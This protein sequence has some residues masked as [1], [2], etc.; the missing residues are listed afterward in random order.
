MLGLAVLSVSCQDRMEGDGRIEAAGDSSFTPVIASAGGTATIEFTTDGDWN[1]K[2]PDISSY[3][4]SSIIPTSGG[5]G[6]NV[7]TVTALRNDGTDDRSFTFDIISGGAVQNVTVTQRQKNALTVTEG[8]F[9][10]A[11]EGGQVRI[12]V[13]ANVDYEYSIEEAAASWIVPVPESRA[14]DTTEVLLNV[15]PNPDFEN[16]RTGHVTIVSGD[17]SQEITISQAALERVFE[18]T[19]ASLEIDSNGG[20]VSFSV[21]ANFEYEVTMEENDW[22][23]PKSSENGTY[24][25]TAAVNPDFG[26]RTATINVTTGVEGYSAAVT[27]QQTGVADV[28]VLW[29]HTYASYGVSLSSPVLRLAEYEDHLLVSTGSSVF[30]VNRQTGEYEQAVTLPEGMTVTSLTNDDAGN[31]IF[32]ANAAYG[33][34]LNIYSMRGMSSEPELVL[35]YD[36]SSIYSASIGNVRVRGDVNGKAVVTAS[37]DVSQYWVAWQIEGGEVT[38]TLYGAA[39]AGGSTVWSPESLC[40]APVSDELSDGLLYIGYT[41]GYSLQ[42]CASP[43]DGTWTVIHETGTD[44]NEN[45]NCIS[46]A[47]FGGRRYA[48]YEQGA[49]FSWG[50]CPEAHLI[51]ITDIAGA[52]ESVVIPSEDVSGG[53]AFTETGPGSDILLTVSDDG[54]VMYMFVTDGNYDCLTCITFTLP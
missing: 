43:A 12:E 22:L 33:S 28:N 9:E 4:W 1:A 48:A 45:F 41:T 15:L 19:P 26:S 13:V 8:A 16:A 27:V 32:A 35:S 7:I 5:A 21:N 3:S 52:Y 14:M 54:R 40:T 17:I 31:I 2:V 44:G 29:S 38:E 46:V 51:D 42:Y 24:T 37:V 49:Y 36:H 30:A 34:T 6:T 20:D 18:V 47:D 39:P 10:V 50:S 25:Y 11:A 53:A 23:T